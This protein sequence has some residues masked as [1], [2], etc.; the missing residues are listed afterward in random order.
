MITDLRISN[1]KGIEHLS[2]PNLNKLTLIVG[3][4]NA[5]KSTVLEGIFFLYDFMTPEVFSKM[6]NFRDRAHMVGTE[7]LWG[8]LFF[9]GESAGP[10]PTMEISGTLDSERVV[11]TCRE[12]SVRAARYPS[13]KSGS[14]TLSSV[15]QKPD[16]V[17]DYEIS[18]DSA[19]VSGRYTAEPQRIANEVATNSS[20]MPDL[21]ERRIHNVPLIRGN[22]ELTELMGEVELRNLKSD[23]LETLR[24]VEPE[25]QDAMAVNR[26]GSWEIFL[27]VG[28][29]SLPL[30]LA[31]DG[32]KN[33]MAIALYVMAG[34]GA[35]Y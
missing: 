19:K 15:L 1:F 2:L 3:K 29:R 28:N 22:A 24:I 32:L 17:L 6:N 35:S 9:K 31:G 33:L 5:G 4:N 20:V 8:N 34:A 7:D 21:R 10:E 25:L 13:Q 16:T 30:A 23:L 12:E 11:L 18:Q 14:D 27:R 26:Q